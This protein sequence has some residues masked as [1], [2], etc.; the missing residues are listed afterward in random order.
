MKT[1][2]NI[3]SQVWVGNA[4]VLKKQAILFLQN[5]FCVSDVRACLSCTTCRQ[6]QAEQY[7]NI[8]WLAPDGQYKVEQIREVLVRL[9]L[10]L[11]QNERF[12]FVFQNAHC[13]N[14]AS[15]NSLLKSIEEPPAGYHFLFLTPRKELLLD[16]ILSRSLVQLFDSN[17]GAVEHEIFACFTSKNLN[18]VEFS[19]MLEKHKELNEQDSRVL[20]DQIYGYWLHQAKKIS[21]VNELAKIKRMITILQ[22]AQDVPPMPGSSK[23]F[24]RNL[25]LQCS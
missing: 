16:T 1:S 8:L 3:P 10:R 13:L 11:A 17:D 15:A 5:Q 21:D 22:Q 4:Q 7:Y 18:P 2:I 19:S 12:Y 6:I 23:L 14:E 9:S 25:Y 24:W 20:L